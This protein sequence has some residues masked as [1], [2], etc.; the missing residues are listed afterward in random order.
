MLIT[1]EDEFYLPLVIDRLLNE[2][3]QRV[4]VV[5][6]AENP[7][8]RSRWQ[9]ARRFSKTFGWAQVMRHGVRVGLA[10]LADVMAGGRFI[11]RPPHSVAK[12]CARHGAAVLHARDV[13][14]EWLMAQLR[15]IAPDL[16]VCVSATQIFGEGL[17][18][19]PRLGCINVHCSLLPHYR[20][21]YPS[22]WALAKGE[23]KTGVTVHNM[24]AEIDAG[25]ILVQYEVPIN[26]DDTLHSLVTRTKLLSAD[27]LLGAATALQ[28]GTAERR[29]LDLRRGSY[30][31]FPTPA[32]YREFRARGRRL[33]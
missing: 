19:V 20:G 32:A 30:F 16:I 27:A 24:A 2:W 8:A 31:S 26:A 29:P 25:D 4:P 6:I 1:E 14:A 17:L 11:K 22:F 18:A 12:T 21:L 10:K 3:E 13:N 5:V 15:A 33:W 28:E 7:L 23:E 9:A